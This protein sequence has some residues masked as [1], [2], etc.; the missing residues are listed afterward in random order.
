LTR[1]PVLIPRVDT[2][3][4]TEAVGK[5]LSAAS[6]AAKD[7]PSS[8]FKRFRILDLCT[9]S[10]CIAL[11]LHS[12]LKPPSD[13][14]TAEPF[15]PHVQIEIL[16]VDISPEAVRLARENLQHNI[17]KGLLHPDA[18]HEVS[19]ARLDLLSLAKEDGPDEIRRAF[20]VE[21]KRQD[22]WD[23]V[24]SNPPYISA[25]DYAP[26]GRTEPSVRKYEPKL[27][28]VPP[29]S[30]SAHPE[31][32]FYRP[33]LRLARA[34]EAN[35][36]VVEVG[37]SEQASR[38]HSAFVQTPSSQISSGRED[39]L[40]ECWKDDGSV[41]ALSN[42]AGAPGED[43]TAEPSREEGQNISDRAVLMWSGPLA[44]WRQSQ[45]VVEDS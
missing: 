38:V 24:I 4:Y 35:L 13:E 21:T 25:R 27:A 31:D 5:L 37:D 42:S 29:T 36:L 43:H 44:K 39:V 7:A 17:S 8:G 45:M 15:A 16:G 30:D 1:Q 41:R 34:V 32:L 23:V 18:A 20:N 6:L 10:G 33:L 12:I 11:L 14:Q 40:V 19:F 22:A 2:E 9:G 26:G 3:T 28:L